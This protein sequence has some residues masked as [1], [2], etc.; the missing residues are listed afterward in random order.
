MGEGEKMMKALF[1]VANIYQP[2]VKNNEGFL[3]KVNRLSL[4]TRSTL[5]YPKEKRTITK[6]AEG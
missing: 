5:C 3:L 2:S 4:L 6:Q 1:H